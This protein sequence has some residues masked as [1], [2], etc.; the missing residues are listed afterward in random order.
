M[1]DDHAKN[2]LNRRIFIQGCATTGVGLYGALNS[3]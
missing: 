1:I 2:S 3:M